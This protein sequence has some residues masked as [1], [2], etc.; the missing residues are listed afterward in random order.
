MSFAWVVVSIDEKTG[1]IVWGARCGL[2]KEATSAPEALTL[3]GEQQE[4]LL[5]KIAATHSCKKSDVEKS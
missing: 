1:A 5:R 2:C 4:T 3:S